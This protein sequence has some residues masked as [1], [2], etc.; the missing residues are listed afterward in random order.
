MVAEQGRNLTSVIQRRIQSLEES[1]KP[2]EELVVYCDA[3]K[4]RVRV[5]AIE[6]PNWH[7]AIVCGL[8]DDNNPTQRIANIQNIE[9]TCKVIEIHPGSKPARIGFILPELAQEKNQAER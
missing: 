5:Q 3:G 1:L 2:G 7:L 4:D 9:L 8:D 6:F